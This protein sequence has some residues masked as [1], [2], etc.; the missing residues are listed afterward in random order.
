M[1]SVKYNKSD[2]FCELELRIAK[3]LNR[4]ESETFFILFANFQ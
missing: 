3:E 1:R 4:F 2:N